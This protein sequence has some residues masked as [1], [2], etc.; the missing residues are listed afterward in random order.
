M[1]NPQQEDNILNQIAVSMQTRIN[2]VELNDYYNII[3]M[4][5]D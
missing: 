1:K 4:Y 5:S 3:T 2:D